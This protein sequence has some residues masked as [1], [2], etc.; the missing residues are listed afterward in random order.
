MICIYTYV[1][2]TFC[3]VLILHIRWT[4]SRSTHLVFRYI[5]SSAWDAYLSVSSE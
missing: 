2:T 5:W 1:K 4:Q 3:H